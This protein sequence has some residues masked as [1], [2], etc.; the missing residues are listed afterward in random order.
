MPDDQKAIVQ[1]MIDAGESEENIAAVIQH[2]KAQTPYPGVPIPG[3]SVPVETGA[4]PDSPVLSGVKDMLQPLAHPQTL[5]DM[6]TLALT[7]PQ[8]PALGNVGTAA[9]AVYDS[10]P[11]AKSVLS[12]TL[13]AAGA[14]MQSPYKATVG[15]AGRLLTR[16][17]E[18]LKPVA[19]SAAPAA[20]A[21][22][23]AVETATP[24]ATGRLANGDTFPIGKGSRDLMAQQSSPVTG[25]LRMAPPEPHPL[26]APR[27]DV[28]AEQVGRQA[29]MTRQAVRE[30]TGPVLGEAPGEASPILPEAALGRIVDTLKAMPPGAEREAYVAR[31]TSGK[32]QWQIENIR[33]TLAHLGLIVPIAVGAQ[34]TVASLQDPQ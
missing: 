18:A 9:K 15:G 34:R 11:S 12:G 28:G 7:T 13:R 27:V 32:A 10:L 14:V 26:T 25:S 17:G 6:A 33:R 20:E 31:A 19:E 2:F 23:P 4:A 3:R 1:R 22:A 29:G 24:V 5:G 8:I 16:A 21:A 30:V